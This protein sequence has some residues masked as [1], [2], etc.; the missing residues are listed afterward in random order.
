MQREYIGILFPKQCLHLGVVTWF[1]VNCPCVPPATDVVGPSPPVAA[2]GS[3]AF[4]WVPM[5]SSPWV[6]MLFAWVPMHCLLALF[7]CNA[8]FARLCRVHA[9]VSFY[10]L[11]IS[12]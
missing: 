4:A 12:I 7:A 10:L 2:L 1:L 9:P 6:P 11:I 5:P 8:C 3:Y